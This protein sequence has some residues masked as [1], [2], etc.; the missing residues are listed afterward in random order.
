VSPARPPPLQTKLKGQEWSLIAATQA[1][2]FVNRLFDPVT[3]AC[4]QS[5]SRARALPMQSPKGVSPP[6]LPGGGVRARV[7][8]GER[9]APTVFPLALV[10]SHLPTTNVHAVRLTLFRA[11]HFGLVHTLRLLQR[12]EAGDGAETL[13]TSLVPTGGRLHVLR[14]PLR[15]APT[16]IRVVKASFV[17]QS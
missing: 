7:R 8:V 15:V 12:A 5:F 4:R 10:M 3:G 14:S 9:A 16:W 13:N 17:V 2:V 11:L 6:L 1:P